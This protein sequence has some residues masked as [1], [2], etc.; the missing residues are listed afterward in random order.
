MLILEIYQKYHI[1]E[2][3]QMHMLRVAAC[4]NLI[5][6]HWIG[7]KLNEQQL[8]KILLLHDMGNIVKIPEEQSNDNEFLAIRKK[9]LESYGKDDHMVNDVI[10][11]QEGCTNEEITIMNEKVFMQ[12]KETFQSSSFLRKI[13]AYCDQRVAPNGVVCLQQRME[14]GTQR[15]QNRPGTSFNC[16]QTDEMIRYSF[17]IEKQIMNYCTIKPGDINNESIQSYIEKLKKW[18]IEK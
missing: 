1:P 14:E 5:V 6:D 10:C 18:K 15:Y 2:I 16:P 7:P 11:K 3:L 8:I 12:N 9:Y 4:A 17:E 13:A